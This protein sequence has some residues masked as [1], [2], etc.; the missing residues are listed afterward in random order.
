MPTR[1]VIEYDGSE[2]SGW[3]KQPGRRTVQAELERALSVIRRQPTQLTVA[4]RTDAGVHA[5]AQVASHP[6]EA[7]AARSINALLPNDISVLLSEYVEDPFDARADAQARIYC[8]RLVCARQRL[9][10]DRKTAVWWPHSFERSLLDDCAEVLIGLH[11]FRAFTLSK[12]S[13]RSYK[14]TI[15]DARWIDSGHRTLEFWIE[16][17]SFTRRMVRT[18]VG[19]QLDVASGRRTLDDLVRLL[20]GATRDQA[21][22]SAP[23]HGLFLAGVRYQ[24]QSIA[25]PVT[26]FASSS[27]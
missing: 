26:P 13:Y 11:D 16:S 7:A 1:L 2:F 23:A 27:V 20:A 14:R 12:Q 4:G 24:D 6:G 22:N 9:A 5:W 18:L 19:M 21:A 25:Q 10:I 3:A 15:A 8:Y 17:D